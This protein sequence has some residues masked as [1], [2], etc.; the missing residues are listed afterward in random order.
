M[1]DSTPASGTAAS[2]VSSAELERSAVYPEREAWRSVLAQPIRNVVSHLMTRGEFD[3]SQLRE[4]LRTVC[5]DAKRRGVPAEQVLIAVKEIWA[6]LPGIRKD[7]SGFH[8]A[9]A[10]GRIVALTLD[11]YFEPHNPSI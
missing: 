9:P 11:E 7:S 10:W 3:A 5:A 4:Q 2:G 8:C 6:E 1:S